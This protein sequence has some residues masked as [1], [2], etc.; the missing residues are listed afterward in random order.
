MAGYAF[1]HFLNVPYIYTTPSSRI[2]AR[3]E[4]RERGRERA[5]ASFSPSPFLPSRH[6]GHETIKTSKRG[7]DCFTERPVFSHHRSLP[8]PRLP[9]PPPRPLYTLTGCYIIRNG[10]EG[11]CRQLSILHGFPLSFVPPVSR[12]IISFP[13]VQLHYHGSINLPFCSQTFRSTN[14]ANLVHG[15]SFH[16][17]FSR[18][19]E[20][21][22]RKERIGNRSRRELNPALKRRV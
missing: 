4:E 14:S 16:A 17:T 5:V 2:R 8:P 20:F 3:F 7:S 12:K 9:R 21:S 1:K 19:F 13:H 6:H 18:P 11:V 22:K 10:K 15:I